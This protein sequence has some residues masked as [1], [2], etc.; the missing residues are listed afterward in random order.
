MKLILDH[1]AVILSGALGAGQIVPGAEVRLVPAGSEVAV[2]VLVTRTVLLVWSRE[3]WRPV[4]HLPPDSAARIRPML[5]R[6]EA[7]HVRVVNVTP[8]Q[9]AADG[10]LEVRIS[11]WGRSP[12]DIRPSRPR[13]SWPHPRG[14]AGS[15]RGPERP[16]RGCPGKPDKS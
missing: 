7:L 16:Q 9:L 1:V 5:E 2:M 11:A 15:R 10:R 4:G 3:L 8:P 14:P 6:R 12:P 13:A